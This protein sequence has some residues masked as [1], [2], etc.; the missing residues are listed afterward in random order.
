MSASHSIESSCKFETYAASK[1]SIN[2]TELWKLCAECLGKKHHERVVASEQLFQ[3]SRKER[4]DL[5]IT[6]EEELKDH[7]SQVCRFRKERAIID[8]SIKAA[9]KIVDWIGPT[10]WE[11]FLEVADTYY[12][13]GICPNYQCQMLI[14]KWDGCHH[15][16]CLSCRREFSWHNVNL[17]MVAVSKSYHQATVGTKGTVRT[18]EYT[19]KYTRQILSKFALRRK[20]L[21]IAQQILVSSI[22]GT[23]NTRK[24]RLPVLNMEDSNDIIQ[25]IRENNH[26]HPSSHLPCIEETNEKVVEEDEK[27]CRKSLLRESSSFSLV[28]SIDEL[29]S[30]IY[31]ANS[32]PSDTVSLGDY[33]VLSVNEKNNEACLSCSSS[34][35][36]DEEDFGEEC[37]YSLLSGCDS[38]YS[39]DIVFTGKERAT[40]TMVRSYCQVVKGGD[41]VSLSTKNAKKNKTE[42]EK[43]NPMELKYPEVNVA[44]SNDQVGNIIGDDEDDL[45]WLLYDAAKS[46]HGGRVSTRFRGNSRAISRNPWKSY[47]RPNW[48]RK[49]RKEKKKSFP[50]TYT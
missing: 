49:Q 50:Y 25:S 10:H 30:S 22:R 24:R 18:S 40:T 11:S 5:L 41:A 14:F 6:V 21:K 46:C 42:H 23:N 3:I 16:K 13:I 1:A 31:T 35:E 15:M 37:S 8:R 39:F 34:W 47:R 12:G 43:R 4:Q 2:R 36:K 45:L 19:E 7:H 28:E 44:S 33:I 29:S 27:S 48:S 32:A 38:V 26:Y 9:K 17:D 20:M